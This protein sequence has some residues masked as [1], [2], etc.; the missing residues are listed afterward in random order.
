MKYTFEYILVKIVFYMAGLLSF[1][2]A[3]RLGNLL[4]KIVYVLYPYRKKV[5]L[6]NLRAAFP[7]KSESD[8]EA[9][10]RGMYSHICML[11]FEYV[12][13]YRLPRERVVEMVEFDPPDLAMDAYARGKGAIGYTGH[14]GNFEMMGAALR[15]RGCI[16][17]G[18]AKAMKNPK[19]DVFLDSI[20]NK[21]GLNVI[22]KREGC[23]YLKFMVD[24]R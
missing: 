1:R 23:I 22:K 5:I 8:I 13:T 2:T 17:D 3:M 7:E 4:G 15:I 20:R 6:T 11:L 19:V 10:A 9:I 24:Q 14:F 18:V 21:N 12:K 16:V